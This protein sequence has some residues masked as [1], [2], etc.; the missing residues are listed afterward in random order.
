MMKESR[1]VLKPWHRRGASPDLQPWSSRLDKRSDSE[2][3]SLF[4]FGGWGRFFERRGRHTPTARG[5]VKTNYGGV[6]RR[7]QR[8]TEK[9]S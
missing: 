3:S 5:S 9:T 2:V 4:R 1:G 8:G 7:E 6:K